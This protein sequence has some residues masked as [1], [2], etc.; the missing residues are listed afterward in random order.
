MAINYS[1]LAWEIPRTEKPDWLQ[2]MGLQRVEHD[3]VTDHTQ[4][5][6]N[7]MP[8]LTREPQSAPLPRDLQKA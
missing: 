8:F 7:F 2:S 5:T 1:I 3:S 6:E 4:S